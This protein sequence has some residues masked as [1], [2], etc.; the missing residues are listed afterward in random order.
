MVTDRRLIE[1]VHPGESRAFSLAHVSDVQVETG[2][3]GIATVRIVADAELIEV[4][5]VTEW[6]KCRA[7]SAASALAAGV[8]RAAGTSL[9]DH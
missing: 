1:S 5:V 2:R 9:G 7:A 6:P 4:H 8:R 3:Q